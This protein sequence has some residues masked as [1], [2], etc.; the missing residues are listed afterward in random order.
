MKCT[1]VWLGPGLVQ[2]GVSRY[3]P[4]SSLSAFVVS[5]PPLSLNS[6]VPII[7]LSLHPSFKVDGS[8]F[9]PSSFLPKSNPHPSIHPSFI[10]I[11]IIPFILF[12]SLY[13]LHPRAPHPSLLQGLSF[14]PLVPFPS[15]PATS[16]LLCFA[17]RT[18]PHCGRSPRSYNL[19]ARSGR[20]QG[21]DV[22][23]RSWSIVESQHG[24]HLL[25]N[26]I[27]F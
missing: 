26:T 2:P 25:D 10:V 18:P 24:C 21:L 19:L 23:K 14:H 4:L 20:S 9:S 1:R 7:T 15:V 27:T 6:F 22:V 16:S 13:L 17:A 8:P 11:I 12:C 5:D 3:F